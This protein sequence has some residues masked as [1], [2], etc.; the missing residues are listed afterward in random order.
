MSEYV[1]KH[2]GNPCRNEPVGTCQVSLVTE[3]EEHTGNLYGCVCGWRNPVEVPDV[4]IDGLP[5]PAWARA[6]AAQQEHAERAAIAAWW[7][8]QVTETARRAVR[9]AVPGLP[10]G[11]DV[12]AAIAA[13]SA[14]LGLPDS[15]GWV[16]ES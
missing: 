2:V 9:E 13:L 6:E 1:G 7:T 4:S 15:A 11:K 10:A 5:H 3:Y 14:V 12:T 16:R 8:P